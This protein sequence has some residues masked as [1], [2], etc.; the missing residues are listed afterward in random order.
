MARVILD[1]SVLIAIINQADRHHGDVIAKVG[2]IENTYGISAITL[3]ETLIHAFQE[4][5][6]E[7]DR[8]RER[9]DDAIDFCV[10]L[11]ESIAIEAAKIRA[12]T[13]LKTPDSIISATA[14]V[15]LAELWTLDA[16]LAKAHKGA[17][18]VA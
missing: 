11:A 4:S 12:K 8:I 18:L 9:I 16:R 13:G 14:K 15:R 6:A 3:V 2:N 5:D 1:S 7:G 17:V 10:E